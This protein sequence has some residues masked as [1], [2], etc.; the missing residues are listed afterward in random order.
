MIGAIRI[1]VILGLFVSLV[2]SLVPFQYLFVKARLGWQ[3]SLPRFSIGL[4]HGC[5]AFA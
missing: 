5:W 2:I 1:A 3:Q 4:L